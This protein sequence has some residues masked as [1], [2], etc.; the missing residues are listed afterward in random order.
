MVF[1]FIRV[2]SCADAALWTC[3]VVVTVLRLILVKSI[4][5]D[6]LMTIYIITRW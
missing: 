3:T 4:V 1:K 6:T 2:L 5:F